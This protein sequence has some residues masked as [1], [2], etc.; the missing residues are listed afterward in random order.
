MKLSAPVHYLKRKAKLLSREEKI[1]LNEALRRIAFQEGYNDW[2]LLAAKLSALT[3]AGKLLARLSP[4]DMVLLG[5]R[6]GQG[7]RA[8]F[9]TLEYTERDIQDCFEAI[10]AKCAQFDGVF[11]CDCSDAISADYIIEALASAQS[12]AL[13]VVGY[14]QLL[15]QKREKPELATQV[16]A[17][18]SFA[19]ERGLIV[20]FLSQ[21]DRSYDPSKKPCPDSRDVRL[22]NPLDLRLFNKT[23]FLNKGEIQFQAA[24]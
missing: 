4:G 21:I 1:P 13:V 5:A 23:C 24:R 9:F 10:G 20:V 22:P 7:N 2:S 15:D 6:P 16:R 14:L 11:K 3:P 18:K 12:G 19:R 17:L 8:M